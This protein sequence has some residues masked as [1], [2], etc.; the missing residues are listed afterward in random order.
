MRK[1]DIQSKLPHQNNERMLCLING[2]EKLSH[3]IEGGKK[4]QV[5]GREKRVRGEEQ[6][7]KWATGPRNC[8]TTK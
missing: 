7:N 3:K 6:K 8:V 4:T 2:L 5:W 1:H